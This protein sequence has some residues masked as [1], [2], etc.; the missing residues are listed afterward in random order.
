MFRMTFCPIRLIRLVASATYRENF[1]IIFKINWFETYLSDCS[2]CIKD[3]LIASSH[4]S[5]K[6]GVPQ[7]SVLGP[8]LFL[9]FI[10]DMP[11][12][13]DTD[14]DL[15]ADDTI[16]HATGKTTEEMEPK[17]QVSTCD[18]NTWCTDNNMG[19]HYGNTHI[20]SR[21]EAHDFC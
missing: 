13:L 16:N 4:Q 9:I 14:T 2:Q 1:D 20:C 5:I 12:H 21:L 3:G 10:N 19:V 11:L 18:F 17:L 15:Y 7:G 8:L 6:S